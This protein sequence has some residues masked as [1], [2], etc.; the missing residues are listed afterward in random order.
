MPNAVGNTSNHVQNFLLSSFCKQSVPRLYSL[1]FLQNLKHLPQFFWRAIISDFRQILTIK[2]TNKTAK[3]STPQKWCQWKLLQVADEASHGSF[4][5]ETYFCKTLIFVGESFP[6]AT[7]DRL[8]THRADWDELVGVVHHGDEQV[9]QDDDVDDGERA[10]HDQAPEPREL[11]DPGELK[12]V[13]VDQTE[14]GP[15]QGLACF[16]KTENLTSLTNT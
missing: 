2:K 13:Q 12:V 9:E 15:E 5:F 10:E 6:F 8:F 3:S 7:F 16:P 1:H 14:R 11:L 4:N